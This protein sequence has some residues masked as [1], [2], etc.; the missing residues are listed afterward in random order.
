MNTLG[1]EGREN[2]ETMDAFIITVYSRVQDE[3]PLKINKMVLK[4]S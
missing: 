4:K 3:R 1:E 2:E